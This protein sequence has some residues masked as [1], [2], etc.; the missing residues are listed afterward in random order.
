[1]KISKKKFAFFPSL[2]QYFPH[3]PYVASKKLYRGAGNAFFK[4]YPIDEYYLPQMNFEKVFLG[5]EIYSKKSD[6]LVGRV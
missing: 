5:V 1:V 2:N 3:I 4:S 6:T